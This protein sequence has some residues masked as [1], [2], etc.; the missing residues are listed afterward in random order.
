MDSG[1]KLYGRARRS[2]T[3]PA[4]AVGCVLWLAGAAL[5]QEAPSVE[6][7][8]VERKSWPTVTGT[9]EARDIAFW[10]D[11][12]A[13]K[14]YVFVT[15]YLSLNAS[16][17]NTVMVTYRFDADNPAQNPKVAYYPADPSQTTVTG[18]HKGV[19]LVV[20]AA[21]FVFVVGETAEG[22]NGQNYVTVKYGKDL[23]PQSP[24][25]GEV[26][27]DVGAGVG[28]RIYDNAAVTNGNDIPVDIG[29][30]NGDSAVVVTGTSPGNGTGDDIATVAYVEDDGSAPPEW[31]S[32]GFGDGVRRYNNDAVDGDDRAAELGNAHVACDGDECILDVV[33]VGTSDGYQTGTDIVTIDWGNT[34]GVLR[35]VQ[36]Y[37]SP[38]HG[39][40]VGVGIVV[41]GNLSDVFVVGHSIHYDPPNNFMSSM[42]P[43]YR[44]YVV[45]SYDRFD[46][47]NPGKPRWT[48]NPPYMHGA[49]VFD[50]GYDDVACD[51]QHYDAPYY[52]YNLLWVSGRIGLSS[53]STDNDFGTLKLDPATGSTICSHTFGVT[54]A[55]DEQAANIAP[56]GDYHYVDGHAYVTGFSTLTSTGARAVGTIKLDAFASGSPCTFR[57]AI[58][59]GGGTGEA[60]AI[61]QGTI[62]AGYSKR[63]V[64]VAGRADGASAGQDLVVFRYRQND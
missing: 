3:A 48:G 29:L 19:A 47:Q 16:G 6:Q 10:E 43:Q 42:T 56:L 30:A 15:G 36:R 1:S 21:G 13:D 2:R 35:W 4:I 23:D 7:V 50:W 59:Y 63:D 24:G 51:V 18:N 20:G 64:F 39:N 25:T 52:E 41:G 40:D 17:T 38:Q 60:T 33:V 37:D 53:G 58:F 44:D 27:A 34:D 61:C 8:W 54:T 55:S 22:G 14:R 45:I 31:P 62:P 57:W 5:A 46:F 26:W 28:A 9:D 12:G 49:R 32:D 11:E